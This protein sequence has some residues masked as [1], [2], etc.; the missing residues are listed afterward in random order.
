MVEG[1]NVGNNIAVSQ[2]AVG[3]IVIRGRSGTTVNGLPSVRFNRVA[4]SAAEYRMEAGNDIIL[5]T[6]LAVFED[7]FINGGIGALNVTLTGI[8]GGKQNSVISDAANDRVTLADCSA[9]GSISVETK[10]GNDT[11]SIL[12][13]MAFNLGVDTAEGTDSVVISDIVVTE[14]VG[15]FTGTGNDSVLLSSLFSGT[16]LTV[17]VDAGNDFVQGTDITVVEDA[18]FEGGASFDT[19][20]DFGVTA[21]IKK[22]IKGFESVLP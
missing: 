6:D 7:L 18:V 19:F 2:S 13:S 17:S 20:E 11:V 10:G 12:A 21:G 5:L 9:E 3:T 8:S 16:S 4:L 22:D 14:D 15:V 1:D